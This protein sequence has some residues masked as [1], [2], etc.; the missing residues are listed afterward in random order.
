MFSL[1]GFQARRYQI[2][3]Q[4]IRK[5]KIAMFSVIQAYG[6]QYLQITFL[7]LLLFMSHLFITILALFAEIHLNK[8]KQI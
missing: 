4:L 1:D 6:I 8:I 3:N 2:H 5:E 7:P